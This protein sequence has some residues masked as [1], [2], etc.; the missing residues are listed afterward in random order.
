MRK[1]NP[2]S[3]RLARLV[4]LLLVYILICSMGPSVSLRATGAPTGKKARSRKSVSQIMDQVPHRVGELL[5]HFRRGLTQ[6]GITSLVE[7]NGAHRRGRLRGGSS[8]ERLVV[9][10]GQNEQI[11]IAGLL[12]DPNVDFVEPNY[13]IS[14]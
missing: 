3:N 6:D 13:I 2:A 8:V 7:R 1:L 9:A 10:A 14:Q 5:I 4:S 11:V 12:A